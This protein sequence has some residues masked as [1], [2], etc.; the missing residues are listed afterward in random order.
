MCFVK[1]VL[2]LLI[3]LKLFCKNQSMKVSFEILQ[4]TK[5][6]PEYLRNLDTF[7][8]YK[9]KIISGHSPNNILPE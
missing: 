3:P 6:Y 9:I 2:K 1:I 7:I 4:E 8:K 5:S